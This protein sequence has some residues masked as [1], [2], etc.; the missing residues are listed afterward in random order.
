[1]AEWA[2]A[3]Q[4]GWGPLEKSILENIAP[5]GKL[6]KVILNTAKNMLEDALDLP[7]GLPKST[8]KLGAIAQNK[9]A[10]DAFRDDVATAIEATGDKV[11]KEVTIKT[12]YGNRRYD[13]MVTD[14]FGRLKGFIEA[15]VG[16]SRYLPSQQAKDNWMRSLGFI[17]DVIRDK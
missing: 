10:G 5:G 13:M 2:S 8:N 11:V 12:P 17:V 16:S 4:D 9:K 14:A 1:M 6:S 7:I 15:K 3:N